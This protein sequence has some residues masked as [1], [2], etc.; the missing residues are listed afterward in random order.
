MHDVEGLRN[1]E[2]ALVGVIAA[3][4]VSPSPNSTN[5]SRRATP[6]MKKSPASSEDGKLSGKS[7]A[8]QLRPPQT[9]ASSSSLTSN[10]SAG[11]KG[12]PGRT[13][14]K[15][16]KAHGDQGGWVFVRVDSDGP[17]SEAPQPPSSSSNDTHTQPQPRSQ[18]QSQPQSESN[19][20]QITPKFPSYIPAYLAANDD[21][22][23]LKVT[24]AAS[25]L[26]ASTASSPAPDGVL[27]PA[28]EAKA[29]AIV[30]MDALENSK[31]GDSPTGSR[32]KDANKTAG[33]GVRRFLSLTRK[34]SVSKR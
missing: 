19:S 20:P 6:N 25:S 27:D 12:S 17:Q 24:N 5:A 16:V 8:P 9:V 22:A 1:S 28:T 2:A 21:S 7:S 15:L 33:G 14:T 4:S 30:I 23:E 11:S 26:S 3:T 31:R 29:K 18:P 32:T 34:S 10:K 13:P